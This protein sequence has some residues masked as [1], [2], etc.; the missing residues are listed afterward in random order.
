MD[1]AGNVQSWTGA[2][3]QTMVDAIPPSAAVQ[4]LPP[5]TYAQAFLVFWT[6]SDNVGGSGLTFFDVEYRVLSGRG[7]G[8]DGAPVYAPF[9]NPIY[10]SHL[11]NPVQGY[12]FELVDWPPAIY[13]LEIEVTDN[14]S[15]ERSVNGMTFRVD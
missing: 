12:S 14:L 8:E 3:A 4:P 11:Q 5:N 7:V 2:Q 15:G 9:G 10:L 6:G 1:H 13:R